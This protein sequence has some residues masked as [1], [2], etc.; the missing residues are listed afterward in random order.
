MHELSIT[1]SIVAIACEHA[2]GQRVSCVRLQIGK[3]SAVMPESIRFCFE[4]CAADTVLAGATLEIEE[5]EG[6]GR[7][8]DCGAEFAMDLP[9]GRCAACG[10]LQ[11]ELLAGSELKIRELEVEACV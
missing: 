10:S 1:R 6:R 2:G 5:I 8:S 9:V 3:L 7:C 4:V 11:V